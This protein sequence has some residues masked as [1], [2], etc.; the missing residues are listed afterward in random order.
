MAC[1]RYVAICRP[2]R[3]PVLMNGKTCLSMAVGSWV[4][5]SLNS[6]V[7][8][9]YTMRLPK[10]G[11]LEIDHFFCEVMAVLRLSCGDTLTYRLTIL[12]V[13]IVLLLV[14][15]GVIFS[16]YAVI[17]LTVLR[18][19]SREGR[20]KALATCSSHLVVVSLFYGP[21]VVTSMT[22]GSTHSPPRTRPCLCSLQSSPPR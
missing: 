21:T 12:G 17:F 11:R 14:P 19:S 20:R 13:G 8:T 6:L 15:F 16:S 3:Y 4:G 2:L 1:D 9:V 5:G 22:P 7:Q 10:C 18:M